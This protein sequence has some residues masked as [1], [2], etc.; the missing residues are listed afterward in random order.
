[1]MQGLD[2][3]VVADVN[4]LA[5]AAAGEYARGAAPAIRE[6]GV[7]NVALSGGPISKRVHAVIARG[8]RD[9]LDWERIHHFLVDERN[10]PPEHPDSHYGMGYRALFSKLPAPPWNV[11]RWALNE[12]DPAR[13]AEYGES[14]L[15]SHFSLG[16]FGAPRFDFVLLEL[17]PDGSVASLF[18]GE[19]SVSEQGRLA[20][21]A[22][23]AA[24]EEALR[25]TM[26]PAVFRHAAAVALL[27]SGEDRAEPLQR[28]LADGE[29]P[30][31]TPARAIRPD[32]GTLTVIADRAA[33]RLLGPRPV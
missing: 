24:G 27:A 32:R 26:T 16:P 10:V 12:F 2:I 8:H 30:A 6:R 25:V 20:V 28:A 3:R 21:P 5:E 31:R 18:P 9:R 4:E 19:G 33:A 29:S 15:R 7:Y 22:P 13:A 11:H 17:G 23:P 1:M 14:I